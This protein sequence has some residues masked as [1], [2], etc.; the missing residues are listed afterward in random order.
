MALRVP[1][2]P[3]SHHGN[4]CA[5]VRFK[6]RTPPCLLAIRMRPLA[7]NGACLE[8]CCAVIVSLGRGCVFIG[9]RIA[10]GRPVRSPDLADCVAIGVGYQEMAV[11][12]G[13][14][15]RIVEERRCCGPFVAR[16][17]VGAVRPGDRLHRGS[18]LGRVE[19]ANAL[20]ALDRHVEDLV[21]VESDDRNAAENRVVGERA[22]RVDPAR[23]AYDR[24]GDPS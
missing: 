8:N 5:I 10:S 21:G 17:A 18:R 3:P 19:L 13:D 15:G 24:C 2:T 11:L 12:Y 6:D 22:V 23:F 14:A 7:R 16:R 20:L 4:L 1:G 9:R